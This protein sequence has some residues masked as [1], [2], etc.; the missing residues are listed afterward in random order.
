M[1]LLPIRHGQ[2]ESAPIIMGDPP[3][4]PG[5]DRAGI[6]TEAIPGVATAADGA[7]VAAG[8]AAAETTL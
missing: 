1:D 3:V 8:A 2:P 6:S 7:A 4:G 5:E